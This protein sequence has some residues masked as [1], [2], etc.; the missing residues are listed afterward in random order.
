MDDS[1]GV[2]VKQIK[3]D[4]KALGPKFGTKM[5]LVTAAIQ[6]LKAKDIN[7]I[8]QKGVLEISIE[9]E[10]TLCRA[11]RCSDQLSRTLRDG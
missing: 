2:L 5:K 7:E 8:E 10:K 11:V 1:S 3:P 9:G 6:L 4:F